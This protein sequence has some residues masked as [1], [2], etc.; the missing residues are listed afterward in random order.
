MSDFKLPEYWCVKVTIDNANILGEFYGKNAWHRYKD[1]IPNNYIGRYVTSHNKANY[2][3]V[4]SDDPGSNY[5]LEKP[6]GKFKEITFEQFKTY[7]L[8]EEEFKVGDWVIFEVDKCVGNFSHYKTTNW[9]RNLTLP[10]SNVRNNTLYFTKEDLNKYANHVI[11][12]VS[13]GNC[14]DVF[15]KATQEEI[16]TVTKIEYTIEDLSNGKCAV[17]NDGTVEELRLVLKAAFPNTASRSS[18]SFKYYYHCKV[19]CWGCNNET[20]LPQQSVKTFLKQLNNNKQM[21][22]IGYKLIKEDY[23]V[24]AE[25]I[26]RTNF[27]EN[28]HVTVESCITRLK[29]ANVLDLWFEPVYKPE[30]K[31]FKMQCD[32]GT[33]ELEVSSKGI[34]YKPE[35]SWLNINDIALLLP[36][37]CIAILRYV[38]SN[39]TREKSYDIKANTKIDVGCKKNTLISEWEQVYNYYKS[40]V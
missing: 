26:M 8:K 39:D 35:D 7:V 33:F 36:N 21:E 19:V 40:L 37:R 10:V 34:Y 16:D 32:D 31:V 28:L 15:R 2:H 4:F 20:E 30:V 6:S 5:D 13:G 38:K 14:I 12:E 9:D 22:I 24:P 11:W 18:G 23:K 17:I 3:S 29:D 25:Y 27:S 1:I